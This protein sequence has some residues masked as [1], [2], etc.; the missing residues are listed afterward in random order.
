MNN[1]GTGVNRVE[2]FLGPEKIG[3]EFYN[4]WYEP[5]DNLMKELQAPLYEDTSTC[6]QQSIEPFK[7]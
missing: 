1:N 6:R 5:A 4:D 7:T 3:T 2:N